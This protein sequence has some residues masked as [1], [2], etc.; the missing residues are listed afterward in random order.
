MLPAPDSFLICSSITC[1]FKTPKCIFL[2][3][4]IK[5]DVELTLKPA[6]V[7]RLLS[8]QAHINLLRIERMHA[9]SLLNIQ[10]HSLFVYQ[11]I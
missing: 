3:A 9:I 7:I 4:E 6:S 1:G 2:V 8:L 5:L 11:R 10:H